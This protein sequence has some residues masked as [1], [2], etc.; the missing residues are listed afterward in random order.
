MSGQLLRDGFSSGLSVDVSDSAS[1]RMHA[2]SGEPAPRVDGRRLHGM[3]QPPNI[4]LKNGATS[5]G[6]ARRDAHAKADICEVD[7]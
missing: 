7:D 3:R 1:H 2:E 6:I 5:V 4:S